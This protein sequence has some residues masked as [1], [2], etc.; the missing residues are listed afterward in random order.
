MVNLKRLPRVRSDLILEW[1]ATRKSTLEGGE[2]T[3]DLRKCLIP[4]GVTC[5]THSGRRGRLWTP[6]AKEF[7]LVG[8]RRRAFIAVAPILCSIM[9]VEMKFTPLAPQLS[10]WAWKPA[11]LFGLGPWW[12]HPTLEV[13]GILRRS[14]LHPACVLVPYLVFC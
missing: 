9:S 6:L 8:Y 10:E 12:G 11:L 13:V 4:M 2:H 5:P 14:H 3:G 1:K 7:Q